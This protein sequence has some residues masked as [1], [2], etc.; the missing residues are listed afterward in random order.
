[1]FMQ[2]TLSRNPLQ[3]RVLHLFFSFITIRYYGLLEYCF[4]YVFIVLPTTITKQKKN[5]NS[6]RFQ[7]QSG[8]SSSY[9]NNLDDPL[10]SGTQ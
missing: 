4:E 7:L 3:K 8:G 6:K 5:E 1:M 10:H 2:G 9:T